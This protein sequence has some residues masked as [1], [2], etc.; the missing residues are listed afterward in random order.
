MNELHLTWLFCWERIFKSIQFFSQ[1]FLLVLKI[2]HIYILFSTFMC[3]FGKTFW[4]HLMNQWNVCLFFLGSAYYSYKFSHICQLFSNCLI[5]NVSFCLKKK[6][7][8]KYHIPKC[9]DYTSALMQM[10]K[11]PRDQNYDLIPGHCSLEWVRFQKE[12][13]YT[14]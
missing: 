9:L 3:V 8:L 12:K 2:I 6:T 5:W 13:M 7:S 4:L 14:K 11:V 1:I 10:L